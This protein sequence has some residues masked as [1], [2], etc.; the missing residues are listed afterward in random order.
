M[1]KRYDFTCLKNK[2]FFIKSNIVKHIQI[3]TKIKPNS[4]CNNRLL[5]FSLSNSICLLDVY[6]IWPYIQVYSQLLP[7]FSLLHLFL[8]YLR[9]P[10]SHQLPNLLYLRCM[11]N[12]FPLQPP[13]LLT[14]PPWWYLIMTWWFKNS[15]MVISR[16]PVVIYERNWQLNIGFI[17]FFCIK[18]NSTLIVLVYLQKISPNI[19]G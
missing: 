10:K 7:Q 15:I 17:Y 2:L 12:K 11:K 18:S 13:L 16:I 1:R 6:N 3:Y 8:C 19:C 5:L 9:Y 14:L 4:V